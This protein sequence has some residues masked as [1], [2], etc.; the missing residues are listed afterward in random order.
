MD[1]VSRELYNPDAPHSSNTSAKVKLV[2][3]SDTI[4]LIANPQAKK[5]KAASS[6]RLK[7]PQ[8][9]PSFVSQRRRRDEE[10][11]FD[12]ELEPS[13]T[14]LEDREEIT[15]QSLSGTFKRSH[16]AP[17]DSQTLP[18]TAEHGLHPRDQTIDEVVGEQGARV[19]GEQNTDAEKNTSATFK[20]QL[21]KIGEGS[22]SDNTE[23]EIEATSEFGDQKDVTSKH[24]PGFLDTPLSRPQLVRN[25]IR[26]GHRTN[27]KLEEREI[28]AGRN[29]RERLSDLDISS[30]LSPYDEGESRFA[31]NLATHSHSSLLS[32]VEEH[33]SWISLTTPQRVV[34]PDLSR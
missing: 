26:E 29:S 4:T 23:H 8:K 20:L 22:Q 25:A 17:L 19:I 14:V 3:P 12:I 2:L 18:H 33:K 15:R 13:G 9:T 10:E 21:H 11:I 28:E 34:T 27:G 31:T 6:G 1:Q 16:T 5:A 30:L 32:H 7:K 24:L